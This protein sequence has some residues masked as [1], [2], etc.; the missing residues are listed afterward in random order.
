MQGAPK[1]VLAIAT[2]RPSVSRSQ[3]PCAPDGNQ[4]LLFTL[5]SGGLGERTTRIEARLSRFA[6]A[7]SC[8]S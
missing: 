1:L 2:Y 6:H 5:E 4:N 3:N 7:L 8:E